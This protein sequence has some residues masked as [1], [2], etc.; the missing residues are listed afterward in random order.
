LK[1]EEREYKIANKKDLTT[2]IIRHSHPQYDSKVVLQISTL[3]IENQ[4]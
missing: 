4:Y 2:L 1:A 3:N